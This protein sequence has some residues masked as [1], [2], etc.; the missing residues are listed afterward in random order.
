MISHS[1]NVYVMP[2]DFEARGQ[3]VAIE[4]FWRRSRDGCRFHQMGDYRKDHPYYYI[5]ALCAEDRQKKKEGAFQAVAQRS[6]EALR[7]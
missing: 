7:Q 1:K 6:G 3:G 5:P 4:N 2:F